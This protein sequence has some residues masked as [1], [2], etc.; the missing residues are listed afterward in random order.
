M[1][2]HRDLT[3]RRRIATTGVGALAIAGVVLALSGFNGRASGIVARVHAQDGLNP[4]N[5][6]C[7][8]GVLNGTYGFQRHGTKLDGTL[9]SSVGN[10]MFDG[11]GSVVGGQEWTMRNGVLTYRAIPPGTYDINPDCTGQFLD[12][13]L[14]PIAQVVVVHSGSEVLGMS[15]SAGNS[16]WARFEKV[17]DAPGRPATAPGQP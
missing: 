2:S 11:Q 5:A 1:T 4:P 12:P 16:V 6:A 15:L 14:S 7:S 3:S 8:N 17:A 9:I 10:I 13:T